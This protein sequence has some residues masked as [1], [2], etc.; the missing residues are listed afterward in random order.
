MIL[1][2]FK[3]LWAERYINKVIVIIKLSTTSTDQSFI[4]IPNLVRRKWG[5]YHVWTPKSSERMP[6]I[7]DPTDYY[8]LNVLATHR[9]WWILYK[10]RVRSLAL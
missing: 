10:D 5:I 2:D 7:W 8:D 1:Y 6:S 9:C 3:V 4:N